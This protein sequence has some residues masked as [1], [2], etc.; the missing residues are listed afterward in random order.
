MFVLQQKLE[1]DHKGQFL[2]VNH[3]FCRLFA[4]ADGVFGAAVRQRADI[5]RIQLHQSFF[6][7]VLICLFD[8]QLPL[9]KRKRGFV[10]AR[11]GTVVNV[12]NQPGVIDF[13]H[14]RLRE[15]IVV[16][17]LFEQRDRQPLSRCFG[18]SRKRI[19]GFYFER[20]D[21]F[22]RNHAVCQSG[23]QTAFCYGGIGNVGVERVQSVD[24]VLFKYHQ[25]DPVV[26]F[27]F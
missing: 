22:A 1:P 7:L 13:P 6:L 27:Q 25:S 4:D 24:P 16:C 11:V 9:Q 15:F 23:F 8:F 14:C 3:H 12:K 26:R 18:Y 19:G 21:E 5:E 10:L 17:R 2:V 20:G